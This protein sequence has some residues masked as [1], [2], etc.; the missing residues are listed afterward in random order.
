M[1]TSHSTL[2]QHNFVLQARSKVHHWQGHGPLS[3]K[4]FRGGRAYYRTRMGHYAVESNSY[5]LLNEGEHYEINIDSDTEVDSFC[6]FFKEGFVD[7]VYRGITLGVGRQLDDPFSKPTNSVHF[8]AKSYQHHQPIISMMEQFKASIPVMGH[9]ALWID[10]QYQ[11]LVHTLLTVH[12]N[13]S[14]EVNTLPGARPSTR[15]ELYR[16]LTIAYEYLHAYYDRNVTLDEVS[17]AA[18]LSKN[19]LIRGFRHLFHQTPHQFVIDKR[20]QEALRLLLQTDHS[21]TDISMAIGF[22]HV[23]SFNKVF[24]RR[25]GC[26]PVQFRKR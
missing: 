25:T 24:K 8:Y 1:T 17:A 14:H 7:E 19:H 26:S 3:I 21:V 13:M 5:L 16:R 9:G 20:M 23:S 15:E 18:C 11:Q 4:T 22:D 6:V 10:E 2:F 12:R